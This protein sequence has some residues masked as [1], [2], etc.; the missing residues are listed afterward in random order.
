VCEECDG[1]RF[2][3]I[4]TLLNHTRAFH[5]DTPKA[6][7]KKKELE[8]HQLLRDAGFEFSY[9]HH[10]PFKRCGLNSETAGA[11]AD[12][13]LHTAWGAIILEV[14]EEQHSHYDPSCDVRRDFDMAS[15]VT[16]GS[17]H[18]LAIVRYN[19]DPFK[20]GGVT[21]RTAK[22]QR[23]AKLLTLLRDLLAHEP[24]LRLNRLFLFYD[25]AASDS[26]LPLVAEKWDDPVRMVSK[27][28]A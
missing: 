26:T 5:G 15:S 1:R 20:V 18:K 7:T 16:L 21:L 2:C 19:P 24:E 10:L 17:G 23:H 25:R 13:V 4:T 12:F 27:L 8:I 9:Q 28:V 14:D 3:N 6:V 22:K 11:Y